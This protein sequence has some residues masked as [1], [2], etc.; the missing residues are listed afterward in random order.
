MKKKERKLQRG[1]KMSELNTKKNFNE[2]H[3]KFL[4]SNN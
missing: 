2:K 1:E 4:D 3:K